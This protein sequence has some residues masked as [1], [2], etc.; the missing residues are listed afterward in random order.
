MSV[1]DGQA[2]T[3]LDHPWVPVH[4]RLAPCSELG[5]DLEG[6]GVDGGEV[7]EVGQTLPEPG[8]SF[9]APM[10][11]G[12]PPCDADQLECRVHST[13]QPVVLVAG[14]SPRLRAAEP[15][16]YRFVD[17]LGGQLNGLMTVT[18]TRTDSRRRTRPPRGT[19]RRARRNRRGG[20]RSDEAGM[21]KR[22]V[23][24]FEVIPVRDLD[25]AEPGLSRQS[26]M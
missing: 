6:R 12:C 1:H 22:P 16:R 17:P 9:A 19:N 15:A 10:P 8:S 4:D 20:R 18:P 14:R 2:S 21:G 13:V 24:G 23:P 11:R 3:P 5:N 26:A 25:Q 7:G